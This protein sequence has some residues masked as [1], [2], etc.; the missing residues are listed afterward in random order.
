MHLVLLVV[1]VAWAG[2]SDSNSFQIP[3]SSK[4]LVVIAV[5]L[6]VVGIVVATRWGRRILRTHV[7]DVPASESWASIVVLRA[8][9]GEDRRAVRRLDA[10]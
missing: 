3:A 8:L 2:Q 6:A 5:V 1:F 9:A 7:V 4:L 10:A